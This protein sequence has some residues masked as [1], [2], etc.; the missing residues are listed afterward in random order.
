MFSAGKGYFLMLLMI[1][2]WIFLFRDS[3]FYALAVIKSRQEMDHNQGRFP[4]IPVSCW[5]KFTSVCFNL[6]SICW[7]FTDIEAMLNTLCP[8]TWRQSLGK[9]L[10][11]TTVRHSNKPKIKTKQNHRTSWS[12]DLYRGGK[13]AMGT[14]ET[15]EVGFTHWKKRVEVLGRVSER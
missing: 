7:P 9:A 13:K 4:N 10:Q 12:K 5:V 6:T 8:E 1:L 14:Q 15:S 2:T 3:V 11:F